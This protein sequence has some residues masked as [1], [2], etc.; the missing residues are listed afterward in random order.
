MNVAVVVLSPQ[1]VVLATHLA[2]KFPDW[3]IYVHDAS[4]PPSGAIAFSRIVALTAEIF[5]Q[6]RGLV[7][8]APCGVVVRALAANLRNKLI[9]PAVVM[10]D[11]G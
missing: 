10:V 9:D 4:G 2:R 11:A 5:E 8:I 7:Y 3:Q 6:Y 1:G